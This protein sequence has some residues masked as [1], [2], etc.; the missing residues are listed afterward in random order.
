[1]AHHS[2]PFMGS[3]WLEPAG[4]RHSLQ[5]GPRCQW[6]AVLCGV[7]S[8][9]ALLGVSEA[10][11]LGV[12]ERGEVRRVARVCSPSR[13][14]GSGASAPPPSPTDFWQRSCNPAAPW[15]VLPCKPPGH[16]P[17]WA[18]PPLLP[19]GKHSPCSSLSSYKFILSFR[20]AAPHFS[21]NDGVLLSPATHPF[22][23]YMLPGASRAS[24]P[25]DEIRRGSCKD[26][27]LL[28]PCVRRA[29]PSLVPQKFRLWL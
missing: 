22:L 25:G 27:G 13:S 14:A 17:S 26:D 1:M 20:V 21:L 3:A 18:C 10:A 11:L 16:S 9:Q 4:V 5:L 24:S 15:P 19:W 8:E 7:R 28:G 12:W 29:Q 23:Y 2:W 6:A